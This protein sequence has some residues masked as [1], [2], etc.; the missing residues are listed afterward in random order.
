MART[1][2]PEQVQ[3]W[4]QLIVSQSQSGLSVPKFC[5]ANDLTA[6]NQTGQA[7]LIVFSSRC[8]YVHGALNRRSATTTEDYW[9]RPAKRVLAL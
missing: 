5:L 9:L 2:S 4:Q 6:R 1:T 7:S 8:T 3:R